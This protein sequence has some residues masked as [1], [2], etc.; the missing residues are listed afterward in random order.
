MRSLRVA[1]AG[2]GTVGGGISQILSTNRTLLAQ[3]CGGRAIDLVAVADQRPFAEL[4][5]A[6]VLFDHEGLQHYSD[7]A[8]MAENCDVDVG[9]SHPA[10]A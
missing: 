10:A 6:G 8:D 5:D 9:A 7:A 2:V 3:R 1:I 4:Q